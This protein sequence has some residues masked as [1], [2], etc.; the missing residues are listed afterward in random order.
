MISVLFEGGLRPGELLSMTVGS[1][2]FNSQYC[3]IT[4]YGKT[5]VKRIPLVAS[6]K[7]LLEWLQKHPLRGE[8][9]APL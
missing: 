9:N 1:V 6:F 4:V 2:A 3:L 5:G 7:P 8:I